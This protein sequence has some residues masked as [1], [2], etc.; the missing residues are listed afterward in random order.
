M[1]LAYVLQGWP[2]ARYGRGRSGC[3]RRSV[4]RDAAATTQ[5]TTA[6]KMATATRISKGGFTASPLKWKD[7][8]SDPA[9]TAWTQAVVLRLRSQDPAGGAAGLLVCSP[10]RLA[11]ERARVPILHD[12][13]K[14]VTGSLPSAATASTI[15]ARLSSSG[16]GRRGEHQEQERHP[17]RPQA[18]AAGRQ[19]VVDLVAGVVVDTYNGSGYF[20]TDLAIVPGYHFCCGAVFGIVGNIRIGHSFYIDR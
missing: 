6:M 17:Q 5:K 16:L 10:V 18:V 3:L 20:S 19:R 1:R 11:L 8:A 4:N 9:R 2:Q 7:A 12:I 13:R 14:L 15:L